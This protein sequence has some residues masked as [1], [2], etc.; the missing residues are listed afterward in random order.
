MS[1]PRPLTAEDL[2]AIRERC[3]RAPAGRYSIRDS[4]ID[5]DLHRYLVTNPDGAAEEGNWRVG[6]FQWPS[7]AAFHVRARTDVPALLD[8]IAALEGEVARLTAALEALWQAEMSYQ[9][10]REY[11]AN[12]RPNNVEAVTAAYEAE[13]NA[14]ARRVHAYDMAVL[15]GAPLKKEARHE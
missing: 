6:S 2:A 3:D 10:A 12:G 4:G 8:H 1:A 14:H 7:D 13:R 11:T 9:V 5:G 15:A